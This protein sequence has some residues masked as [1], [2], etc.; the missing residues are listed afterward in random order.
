MCVFVLNCCKSFTGKHL[1]EVEKLNLGCNRRKG[2]PP[3][4]LNES[5]CNSECGILRRLRTAAGF[6]EKHPFNV[7]GIDLAIHEGSRGQNLLLNGDGGTDAF[8][9]K[10]TQCP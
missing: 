10:L 6:G 3:H 8:Y 5:S 2:Y 9:L 1:Q 4:A 7:G